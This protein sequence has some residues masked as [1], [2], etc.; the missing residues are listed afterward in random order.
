MAAAR[1]F[2]GPRKTIDE[3]LAGTELESHRLRRNLGT[4]DVVVLGVGAM[5]GAGIF[6]LNRLRRRAGGDAEDRDAADARPV[7]RRVRDEP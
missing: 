5:I 1:A 2:F 6:V 4:L 7:A 3:T